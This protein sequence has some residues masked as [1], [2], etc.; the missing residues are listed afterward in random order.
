MKSEKIL[1]KMIQLLLPTIID[2]L[3]IFGYNKIYIRFIGQ[4]GWMNEQKV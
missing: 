4:T 2:I 1:L 3:S